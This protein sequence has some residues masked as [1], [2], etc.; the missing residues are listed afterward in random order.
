MFSAKQLVQLGRVLSAHADSAAEN[1]A[2]FQRLLQNLSALVCTQ[3]CPEVYHRAQ[4]LSCDRSCRNESSSTPKAAVATELGQGPASTVVLLVPYR[5]RKAH[6]QNFTRWLSDHYLPARL[7]QQAPAGAAGERWI[8]WVV[9]QAD[10]IPGVYD[11]EFNKGFL[12]NAGLRLLQQ[13]EP[14][15]FSDDATDGELQ[16]PPSTC[17]VQH[18]VDF[19]PAHGNVD[20]STCAWPRQLSAELAC[21]DSVYNARVANSL[22][23]PTNLGGVVSMRPSH[24]EAVNGFSNYYPGWGAEVSLNLYL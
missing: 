3:G 22:P 23:Y 2:D 14:R 7:S 21:S 16:L 18:D 20:Y 8:V 4:N 1:N 6:L 5:H 17:I 19:L 11:A 15:L 24:W 12:I 10:A 9:E 13:H